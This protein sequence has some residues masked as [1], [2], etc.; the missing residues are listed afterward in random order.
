[1]PKR[2]ILSL[3]AGGLMLSAPPSQAALSLS[4]TRVILQ[5]ASSSSVEVINGSS[6]RYGMQAWVE[7]PE[8][9]DPGKMLVVTPGLSSVDAKKQVV[10][11]LLSFGNPDNKEQLY[12]LNVQEIP[13]KP[14]DNGKSQFLLAVRTKI[15]VLVRPASLFAARRGAEQKIEV[16]KTSHGLHFKNP[17]PYYFAVTT[18]TSGGKTVSKTALGT[19]APMSS[20]DVVF[21]A[22]ASS[23]TV[24]YLED[25]GAARS[26]TLPVQ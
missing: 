19:F 5:A 11:R 7:T 6:S 26:I 4:N 9:Q 24:R 22:P 23:V 25:T 3:I 21:A 20:A 2:L 10:L 15:K 14:K 12:Y 16:S 13:P 17:T 8:G 1:M 18:L